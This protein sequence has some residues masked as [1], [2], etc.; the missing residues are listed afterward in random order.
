[1]KKCPWALEST[2]HLHSLIVAEAFWNESSLPFPLGSAMADAASLFAKAKADTRLSVTDAVTTCTHSLKELYTP[3][4]C[5][6]APYI[7]ERAQIANRYVYCATSCHVFIAGFAATCPVGV[8]C[9]ES[10]SRESVWLSVVCCRSKFMYCLLTQW[11]LLPET[12]PELRYHLAAYF[13][14]IKFY[15]T[16][17]IFI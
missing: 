9:C 11:M 7:Q 13:F 2:C 5:K 14:C 6:Q 17:Y 10:Y 3:A 12:W 8:R 4:H 15:H 1:M 16:Y